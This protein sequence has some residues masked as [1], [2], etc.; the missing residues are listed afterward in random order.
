MTP[1]LTLNLENLNDSIANIFD[2]AQVSL[3]NHKK[4]CVALYKL[5]IKAAAITQPAKKGDGLRL[6]GEKAFQDV[7]IDMVN[8]VLVVK[9]GPA[10]ADRIIKYVGAYVKFMNEKGGLYFTLLL[11]LLFFRKDCVNLIVFLVSEERSK[12]ASSSVSALAANNQ[13]D[14]DES[15]TTRF[16]SRLLNWLLQGFIAKNKNVRY[17]CTQIVSEMI[18]H[19]GE[20]EQVV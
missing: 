16:V 4:N 15:A 18:S 19:L 17:R 7:F 11:I 6:V 12:T 13:E 3:A 2:Q 14:D 1:K 8:R 10:N 20:I 5:H 9:K